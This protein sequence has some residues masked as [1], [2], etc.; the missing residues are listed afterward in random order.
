M[1]AGQ[2]S[3]FELVLYP[4]YSTLFRWDSL[5]EKVTPIFADNSVEDLNNERL[6]SNLKPCANRLIEILDIIYENKG[7]DQKKDHIFAIENAHLTS[8]NSDRAEGKL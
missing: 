5:R 1:E 2:K 4:E 3:F 6:S 7:G 8:S